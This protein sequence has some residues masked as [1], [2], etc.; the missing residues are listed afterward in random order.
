MLGK[1]AHAP[2]RKLKPPES[3]GIADADVEWTTLDMNPRLK[4]DVVFNLDR[5]EM[6]NPYPANYI[7]KDNQLPFEPSTF[8]EI[9]AYDVLEHYGRQGDY[10][11]FFR[12]FREMWRVLKPGG[13]FIGAVPLWSSKYIWADPG[14][15]RVITD[16]VLSYLCKRWYDDN[17]PTADT[18]ADDPRQNTPLT[19]YRHLVEPYWWELAESVEIPDRGAYFFALRKI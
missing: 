11:G 9:H 8:D 19:D 6:P 14:H 13:Y 15:T 7:F 2:R 5:I 17:L 18:P 10:A 3:A 12:G 16:T 4:P 1:G